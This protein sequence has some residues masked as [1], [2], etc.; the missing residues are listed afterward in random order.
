M[1]SINVTGVTNTMHTPGGPHW[2]RSMIIAVTVV[3]GN[4]GAKYTLYTP[5]VTLSTVV[6]AFNT[7]EPLKYNHDS[8]IG[9]FRGVWIVVWNANV[10]PRE[11]VR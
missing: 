2:R 11:G 7:S 1:P 8:S 9:Y 10:L 3:C 4:A 6:D 5:K